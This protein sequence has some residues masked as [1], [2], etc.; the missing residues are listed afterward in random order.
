[1]KF[2]FAILTTLFFSTVNAQHY[3]PEK[4]KPKAAALHAQGLQQA[5]DGNLREGIQLLQQ[6][7]KI[8]NNFEDAYLSIAGM[9]ADL[10]NYD[11]AI[12]N[13]EKA[14]SIDSLYFRDYNLPYSIDLAGKRIV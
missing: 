13:Y 9:Y 8:D 6:A 2:V 12:I 3:D 11:S 14:R 7:V 4:V 10:Q 1:M 5:T